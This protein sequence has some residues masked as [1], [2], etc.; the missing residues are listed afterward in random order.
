[1]HTSNHS[2]IWTFKTSMIAPSPTMP[3][4]KPG[5]LLPYLSVSPSLS[6]PLSWRQ[7]GETS[8]SQSWEWPPHLNRRV[9]KLVTPPGCRLSHRTEEWFMTWERDRDSWPVQVLAMSLCFLSYMVGNTSCWEPFWP[10]MHEVW[11]LV[12][13]ISRWDLVKKKSGL[14]WLNQKA[15]NKTTAPRIPAW[16]P[17]VVLTRRHSG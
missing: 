8:F 7:E 16:S 14:I 6:L 1:M 5:S 11:V 3:A 17:T 12:S 4:L 9:S 10:K 13:T 15:S 2:L